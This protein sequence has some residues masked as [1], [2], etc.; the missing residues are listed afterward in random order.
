MT[1][2]SLQAGLRDVGVHLRRNEAKPGV[3]AVI[4][5]LWETL[6]D[7]PVDGAAELRQTLAE[8]IG[9][10]EAEV[11]RRMDEHYLASQ[12]GPLATVYRTLGLADA[13]MEERIA[14]RVEFTRRALVPREGA[15]ETLRELRRR[16][17]RVGLI[18]MC[19]EDV[20]AA[21]PET[22]LAGLFDVETFSASCGLI[23]PEPAIYLHTARALGV[24]PEECMFVG[25]GANDELAGA[26]R[27]GMTPVLFLPDGREPYW[28]ELS[29]W[30]GL[31][32]SA[33][34]QVLR[35]LG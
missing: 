20:P 19:S 35:M 31:R 15:V 16:G 12:T 11:R 9:V 29:G 22:Q 32:V 2:K 26:E 3:R 23:K 17:L 14:A 25:D 28:P 18:S 24:E 34:P 33:I 13:H 27:V 6:V 8:R 1:G 7:W 21:W 5:D 10:S 4:F 30:R